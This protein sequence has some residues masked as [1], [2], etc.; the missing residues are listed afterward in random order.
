[1]PRAL[2]CQAGPRQKR[3][4]YMISVMGHYYMCWTATLAPARQCNSPMHLTA[5]LLLALMRPNVSMLVLAGVPVECIHCGQPEH[6][7]CGQRRAEMVKVSQRQSSAL[8]IRFSHSWGGL[9]LLSR[10]LCASGALQN[11]CHGGVKHTGGLWQKGSS[12]ETVQHCGAAQ[13]SLLMECIGPRC[14][15]KEA[16]GIYSAASRSG[17]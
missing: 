14:P 2:C 7:S 3:Q 12:P 4:L 6:I 17:Q 8:V 13:Q 5:T 15:V 9:L 16:G 10:K 1:M 11:M